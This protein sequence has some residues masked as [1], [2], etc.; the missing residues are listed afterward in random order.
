MTGLFRWG[1]VLLATDKGVGLV[2][3]NNL[4]KWA[5]KVLRKVRWLGGRSEIALM[6]PAILTILVL[7]KHLSQPSSIPNRST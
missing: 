2:F 1:V 6:S 7:D 4:I 3:E 5:H